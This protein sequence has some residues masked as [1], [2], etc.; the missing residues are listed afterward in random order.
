MTLTCTFCG[1]EVDSEVFL[2]NI[3]CRQCADKKSR[4]IQSFI[5][6]KTGSRHG[7]VHLRRSTDG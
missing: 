5:K 3:V 6:E 4:A 2:E 1:R 7:E